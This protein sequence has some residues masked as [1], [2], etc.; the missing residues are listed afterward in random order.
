MAPLPVR[1]PVVRARPHLGQREDRRIHAERPEDALAGKG[2]PGLPA[3]ALDDIAHR[4]VHEVVVAYGL[5]ATRWDGTFPALS[6]STRRT[7]HSE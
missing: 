6:A 7:A 1:I 2:L 4:R 5:T 3:Q